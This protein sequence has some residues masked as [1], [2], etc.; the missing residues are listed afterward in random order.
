MKHALRA[1]LISADGELINQECLK[2]GLPP[3]PWRPPQR[4]SL[5]PLTRRR[6]REVRV[7]AARLRLFVV[8]G[9]KN[10]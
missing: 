1:V 3:I 6:M 2:V 4:R 7:R 8:G 9:D 10:G 5:P